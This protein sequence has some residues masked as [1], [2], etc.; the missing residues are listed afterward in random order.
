MSLFG[1]IILELEI[2]DLLRGLN[3]Q[4][5]MAYNSFTIQTKAIA[6]GCGPQLVAEGCLP[7]AVAYIL[8]AHLD[9]T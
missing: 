3:H 7:P 1:Y 4:I 2:S 8:P 6:K 9:L 5:H